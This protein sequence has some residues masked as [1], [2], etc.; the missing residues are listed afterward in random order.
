MCAGWQIPAFPE[1][2]DLRSDLPIPSGPDSPDM[3]RF[4][5]PNRAS[6]L[7]VRFSAWT[8][9]SSLRLPPCNLLRVVSDS[10][11]MMPHLGRRPTQSACPP[12]A[13][14][15]LANKANAHVLARA[16]IARRSACVPQDSSWQNNIMM[17]A[18]PDWYRKQ[19]IPTSSTQRS[20]SP[21]LM[22]AFVPEWEPVPR[23]YPD[24]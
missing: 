22:A 16:S 4:S 13:E 2:G 1:G 10:P 23:G 14:H 19:Q 11:K 7:E 9:R 17:L 6:H 20:T 15:L 3:S 24:I 18:Y 8:T 12:R 21:P 5:R